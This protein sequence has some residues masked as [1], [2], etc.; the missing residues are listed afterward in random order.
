MWIRVWAAALLAAGGVC[1][2][3]GAEDPWADAVLDFDDTG[4]NTGFCVPGNALGAPLGAG[5]LFPNLTHLHSVGTAGS[6]ITLKFD[7][8]VTDDPLNPM[9]MDFIVFGNAYWVGGFPERRWMEP[10]LVEVMQDANNNGLPDDV[11]HVI[12][13][14]RNLVQGV[15]AS[16]IAN[17]APPLADVA[18]IVNPNTTDGDPDNDSEEYDWGYADLGP[19]DLPYRDNYLRP[20]DP[21]TVGL[22]AG[23]GGGDAFDLAWAVDGTGQPAGISSFSFIRVWTLVQGVAVGPITTELD[24]V[25]DIAPDV[26]S[27]GDGVLDEYETRVSGTDPGSAA[28]T[29]LPLEIPGSLGGSAT[30]G[31]L[32]GTVA[33]PAGNALTLRSSGLRSGVR[34]F[35]ATVAIGATGDPGGVVPGLLK[36]GAVVDFDCGVADF[37]AAQV[38]DG[39]FVMAYTNAQIDGLDEE[40]LAPWRYSGGVWTQDGISGVAV[41]GAL[42]RVSFASRYPGVFVLASVSGGLTGPG[43]P[44]PGMPVASPWG[45]AALMVLL[46]G[47]VLAGR[48]MPV[49]GPR[50]TRRGFTLVEL[51]VSIAIIGL[52]AALLLPALGRARAQARQAQGKNNLR[53]LFLANTMYASEHDGY[54]VP[55]A[56]DL[57]DFLLPGAPPDH[58]GGRIRWHGVRETPNPNSAFDP[59]KGPLAEYLPDGGRVKECPVFFEY[60]KHG[61]VSN[62]FEAG[63]GGYG[64][65]WRMWGRSCRLKTTR[66]W[67]CGGGC[68]MWIYSTRRTRSC[69]PRRRCR[70]VTT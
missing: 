10:G 18:G 58:F 38:A 13:G 45:I 14:S 64:I 55:A 9:G 51:L 28:S 35:N 6:Y 53:Q 27:D 62:A 36:S 67:R 54:Y 42:N 69:L 48:R 17:P 44:G 30:A 11:W 29:V 56:P 57:F 59:L 33:D 3:A 23:S 12:P 49:A 16:G 26:D 1:A 46:T 34:D 70:R 2:P 21:F 37:T 61:E 60:R 47:G 5:L 66:C 65:T 7:T 15:A 8:P 25:A 19:V 31:T 52:L 39:E 43:E 32:L 50:S 41:D 20:D 40:L 68:A 22:S 24:A 63:T 4:C